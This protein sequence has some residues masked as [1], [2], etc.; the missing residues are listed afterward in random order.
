[1]VTKVFMELTDKYSRTLERFAFSRAFV[2]CY[3]LGFVALMVA[4]ASSSSEASR[5]HLMSAA[6]FLMGLYCFFLV[7]PCLIRMLC[8]WQKRD[9]VAATIATFITATLLCVVIGAFA[10]SY[11]LL[12]SARN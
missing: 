9:F 4:I 7:M 12:T 8:F 6:V 3:M 2:I 5:D 1:M 10:V 11:R